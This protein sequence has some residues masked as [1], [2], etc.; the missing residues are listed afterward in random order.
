MQV[1]H[2]I[3]DITGVINAV[4]Q[5]YW[6][7]LSFNSIKLHREVLFKQSFS[8]LVI[9]EK[10]DLIRKFGERDKQRMI[11]PK[12]SSLFFPRLLK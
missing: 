2:I 9:V 1:G 12:N 4:L 10:V 8:S 11:H 3:Y 6:A 5:H 7:T